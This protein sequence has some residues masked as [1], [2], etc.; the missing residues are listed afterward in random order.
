MAKTSSIPSFELGGTGQ[1][2]S[3][4]NPQIGKGLPMEYNVTIRSTYT[5]DQ[6][7]TVEA[8]GIISAEQMAQEAWEGDPPVFVHQFK[9]LDWETTRIAQVDNS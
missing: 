5:V 1:S 2:G 7:Y 9:L 6:T 3:M 8:D 4:R